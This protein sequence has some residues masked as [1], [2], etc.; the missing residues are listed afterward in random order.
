MKLKFD[1]LDRT[2]E[3]YK[4]NY[5]D[6]Q[7][8]FGELHR[9]NQRLKVT[10]D[11]DLH[12]KELLNKE[13]SQFKS[14][15]DEFFEEK[16]NLRNQLQSSEELLEKERALNEV[17]L[18]SLKDSHSKIVQGLRDTI[19]SLEHERSQLENK[20]REDDAMSKTFDDYK[21]RAQ[22]A[23]KQANST[24]TTLMQENAD[25]KKRILVIEDE[26]ELAGEA[27]IALKSEQ[28]LL[29]QKI[30]SLT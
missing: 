20:L 12:E 5:E 25:L 4:L 26:M 28:P 6:L 13:L 3:D 18:M 8:K 15:C 23:L 16:N 29:L 14:K 17:S 9:E 19:S 11:S 30:E 22:A 21:K 24:S 2:A 1:N 10:I 27:A 7:E